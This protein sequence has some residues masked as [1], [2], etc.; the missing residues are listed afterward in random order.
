MIMKRC[1]HCL[2][3]IP[4]EFTYAYNQTQKQTDDMQKVWRFRFKFH[5]RPTA[6]REPCNGSYNVA[7]KATRKLLKEWEED[8]ILSEIGR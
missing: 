8:K 3:L 6:L 7:C 4:I 2:E 1:P 5:G